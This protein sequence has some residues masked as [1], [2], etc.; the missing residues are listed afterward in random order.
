MSKAISRDIALLR[1][2]RACEAYRHRSISQMPD[3]MVS[4][5]TESAPSAYGM[6]GVGPE[7]VDLAIPLHHKHRVV[8]WRIWASAKKG[9]VG[10]SSRGRISS[11]REHQRGRAL[12]QPPWHVRTASDRRGRAPA[13][14]GMRRP[15]GAER[16]HRL[17]PRK[18]GRPLEPGNRRTGFREHAPNGATAGMKSKAQERI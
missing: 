9:R 11:G 6:A 7:E 10:P 17:R 5:A 3:L 4:A 15:P 12:V 16:E 14:R 1:I 13:P 8:L 18:R 2:A